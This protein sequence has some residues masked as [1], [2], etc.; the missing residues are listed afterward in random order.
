MTNTTDANEIIR[1]IV[2]SNSEHWCV[3]DGKP[4]LKY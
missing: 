3:V 1:M 4:A 2:G